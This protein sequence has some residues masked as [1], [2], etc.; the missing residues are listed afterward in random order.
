VPPKGAGHIYTNDRN[1]QTLDERVSKMRAGNSVLYIID[2]GDATT[3]SQLLGLGSVVAVQAQQEQMI[4]SIQQFISESPDVWRQNF[5]NHDVEDCT[6]TTFSRAHLRAVLILSEAYAAVRSQFLHFGLAEWEGQGCYVVKIKQYVK[7][8][9]PD[10]SSPHS[11]T[12]AGPMR[13]AICDLYQQTL[14]DSALGECHIVPLQE[15]THPAYTSYAVNIEDLMCKVVW[16]GV[17]N[18]SFAKSKAGKE[19][20]GHGFP[21]KAWYFVCYPNSRSHMQVAADASEDDVVD[22]VSNESQGAIA[23]L[24]LDSS[25]VEEDSM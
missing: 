3:G 16:G 5:S 2:R 8:E 20:P 17:A 9:A 18:I 23:G 22:D 12:H 1:V 21:D 13:F 10:N 15:P 6:L 14:V 19:G 25:S 24:S 4:S 7:I 11:T